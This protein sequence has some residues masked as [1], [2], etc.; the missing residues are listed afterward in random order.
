MRTAI[1]SGLIVAMFG[2]SACGDA[3]KEDFITTHPDA[4][5]DGFGDLTT[6]EETCGVPAGRVENSTDCDDG[7]PETYPQ[8]DEICD[9][10]DNDCDLAVDEDTPEVEWF[11]DRDGDGFGGGDPTPL[12]CLPPSGPYVVESGDCDD[13]DAGNYPDNVEVCDGYDNDCDGIVDDEDDDVDPASQTTYWPDND[14]DGFGDPATEVYSCLPRGNAVENGDDCDDI[15][16]RINPDGEERC[17]GLDD[18]CDGQVD[19]GL[20]FQDWYFDGDGDGYGGGAP[21]NDCAAPSGFVLDGTDCAD[22]DVAV[23]PGAVEV[24]NGVDDNCDTLIDDADPG[25]DC[26]N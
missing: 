4:D 1:W 6:P 22:G 19:N 9:G 20:A 16:A 7:A 12:S 21:Q 26:G 23:N 2:L 13:E 25:V 18:D 11:H 15:D 8:A 14:G 3:C 10:V 5:G 24:C 17:N